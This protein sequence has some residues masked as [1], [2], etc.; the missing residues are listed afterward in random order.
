MKVNTEKFKNAVQV[1]LAGTSNKDLVAQ[2]SH[3]VFNEEEILAYNDK[4]SIC[5]PF[6]TGLTCSVPAEDLSKVL[7]GITDKEITVKSDDS[8]F[9]IISE[10]TN[11]VIQT[12][13]ET[14]VVEDFFA[15]VDF[16]SMDWYELPKNFLDQLA[17]SRFSASSNAL[18]S[19]NLFCVYVKDKAIY[20]GDGH[21]LS[22]LN[23]DSKMEEVLIPSTTI[24]DIVTF[25]NFDE[26]AVSRGWI[27]FANNDGLILSCKTMSGDFP[28]FA[29]IFDNFEGISKIKVDSNLIPILQNL[30]GLVSG[31]EDFMKS[32]TI[33]ITKGRTNISGS[34]EGLKIKKSI[35]NTHKGNSVEFNISPVFLAHILT[36]TD[37]LSI[38]ETSAMFSSD[39]FQHL[40]QLPVY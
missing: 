40:V 16:E 13:V 25:N 28:S 2:M 27:H 12:E 18:D 31:K 38:G 29:S 33:E 32:V 36:L 8:S 22:I 23:L 15:T 34:K 11:A 21:R 1:C 20:S 10:T 4:I 19:N 14:R 3:I 39:T 24:P 30:G 6:E 5:V 17:L 9:S 26:C 35:E 37:N 7:S